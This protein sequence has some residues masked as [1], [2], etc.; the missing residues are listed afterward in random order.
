MIQL[1]QNVKGVTTAIDKSEN[2]NWFNILPPF[3]QEKFT[4]SIINQLFTNINF[5]SCIVPE[6]AIKRAAAYV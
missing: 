6:K 2:D 4:E 1:F 5:A 3:K